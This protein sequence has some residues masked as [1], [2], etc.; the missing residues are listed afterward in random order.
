[1]A[2][3][4]SFDQNDFVGGMS[5]DQWKALSLNPY[6][7]MENKVIQAEYPPASTYKIVTAMAGLEEGVIDAST[8]MFCPGFYS[9]GNRVYR[10][11]KHVGHGEV[12]VVR[13]L[14][15]SCDVYFYRVGEA[16]IRLD[17]ESKGL[18]PTKAW[19]R[20]RMGSGW[21]GGETLSVAIGQ[22]FNLVT[23]LQMA[24]LAGA[25]GNG[26]VKYQPHLIKQIQLLI[27]S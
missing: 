11:W 6:R 22:G 20:K 4:P 8:T 14:S 7:P 27:G 1:M 9:Y 25:V 26:G 5:H 2:S 12:D 19:K 24:V 17:R 21:Q 15:E 13:A 16:G 10:C 3:S 18:V 23:P